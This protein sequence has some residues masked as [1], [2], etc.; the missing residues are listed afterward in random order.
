LPLPFILFLVLMLLTF[1]SFLARTE[2][3]R[4]VYGKPLP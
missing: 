1:I 3:R 2:S 4:T